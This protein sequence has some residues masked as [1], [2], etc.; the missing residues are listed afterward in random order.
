VNT[1]RERLWRWRGVNSRF[2]GAI[3]NIL[4][5]LCALVRQ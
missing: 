1:K 5:E 3:L 2:V 4:N